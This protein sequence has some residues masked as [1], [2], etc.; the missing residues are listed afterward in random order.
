VFTEAG[1]KIRLRLD[2]PQVTIYPGEWERWAHRHGIS[3]GKSLMFNPSASSRPGKYEQSVIRRRPREKGEKPPNRA[4]YEAAKALAD[5]PDAS[6]E[7]K[8]KAFQ[9]ILDYEKEHG[10]FGYLREKQKAQEA[11]KPR[12]VDATLEIIKTAIFSALSHMPQWKLELLW[13]S[14][15]E[16]VRQRVM[17]KLGGESGQM[18]KPQTPTKSF[19]SANLYPLYLEFTRLGYGDEFTIGKRTFTVQRSASGLSDFEA[20][21]HHQF[22]QAVPLPGRRPGMNLYGY[23]GTGRPISIQD[24][25][26]LHVPSLRVLTLM[27][28][29]MRFQ[30][31]LRDSANVYV[32]KVQG[33]AP[34]EARAYLADFSSG[35]TIIEDGKPVLVASGFPYIAYR[36]SERVFPPMDDFSKDPVLKDFETVSV[37]GSYLTGAEKLKKTQPGAMVQLGEQWVV[38]EPGPGGRQK[39]PS[40]GA[41]WEDI[42][43]R[44]HRDLTAQGMPPEKIDFILSRC[45]ERIR[46][47]VAHESDGGR[48][49]NPVGILPIAQ[50]ITSAAGAASAFAAL[51]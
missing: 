2:K 30:G 14:A 46:E 37:E 51:F 43:A 10:A 50:L 35:D 23:R 18:A 22:N 47:L 31:K 34:M 6:F 28:P 19:E 48:V 25:P 11:Q 5:S 39:N 26:E 33:S 3:G 41:T 4:S 44:V 9:V 38:V 12:S 42:E 29:K 45:R 13:E 1:D 27:K 8:Q 40:E 32:P 17:K 21:G 20:P 15:A 36:A 16:M 7:D 24:D 49:S